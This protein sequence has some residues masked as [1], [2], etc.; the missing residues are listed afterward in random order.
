MPT[1]PHRALPR[2]A[3]CAAGAGLLLSGTSWLPGN[4]YAVTRP[5]P[6]PRAT[7]TATMVRGDTRPPWLGTV[8]GPDS[9]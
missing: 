3:L 1:Q 7:V 6:I 8:T 2:L 5:W 9:P 4:A